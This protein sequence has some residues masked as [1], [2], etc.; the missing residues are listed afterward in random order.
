[1]QKKKEKILKY[2]YV[3]ADIKSFIIELFETLLK[4]L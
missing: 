3:S 4:S 2:D 1:M